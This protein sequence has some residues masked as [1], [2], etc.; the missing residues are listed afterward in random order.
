MA[1]VSVLAIS[2]LNMDLRLRSPKK[3]QQS[4]EL[5]HAT[6]RR[7]SHLCPLA[8][9]SALRQPPQDLP[10]QGPRQQGPGAAREARQDRGRRRPRLDLFI[11]R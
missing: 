4:T 5:T 8:R 3:Q 10:H 7:R 9:R 2:R 11:K 1:T 6:G